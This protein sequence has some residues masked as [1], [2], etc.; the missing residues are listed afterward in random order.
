MSFEGLG[1]GEITFRWKTE[2][3]QNVNLKTWELGK[4]LQAEGRAWSKFQEIECVG[5]REVVWFGGRERGM[6]GNEPWNPKLVKQN[7]LFFILQ[8]MNF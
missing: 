5:K 7:N 8:R 1:D 2:D 4:V 3:Q 6:V